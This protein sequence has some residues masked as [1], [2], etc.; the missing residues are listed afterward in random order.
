MIPSQILL[1]TLTLQCMT[2]HA[3]TS[4]FRPEAGQILKFARVWEVPSCRGSLT[5]GW[6]LWEVHRFIDE[7]KKV[8]RN[9][10]FAHVVRF[11]QIC[12]YGK[13][14]SLVAMAAFICH[15]LFSIKLLTPKVIQFSPPSV[16]RSLLASNGIGCG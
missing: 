6:H 15:A 13:F 2:A 11:F 14:K 1:S 7:T 8:T 4:P 16:H 3:A 10:H 9:L 5:K 12:R